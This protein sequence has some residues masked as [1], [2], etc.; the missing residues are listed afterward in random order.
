MWAETCKYLPV[1]HN[2]NHRCRQR[3]RREREEEREQKRW[4]GWGGGVK[5]KQVGEDECEE[6]TFYLEDASMPHRV[7]G[8]PAFEAPRSDEQ[9]GLIANF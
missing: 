7:G 4:V 9:R 8:G 2:V 1:I 3:D 5:N 6:G